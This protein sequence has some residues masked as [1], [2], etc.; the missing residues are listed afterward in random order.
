MSSKLQYIQQIHAV[1]TY[2]TNCDR[3]QMNSLRDGQTLNGKIFSRILT[4]LLHCD[5][6]KLFSTFY[7]YKNFQLQLTVEESQQTV[8]FNFCF[9]ANFKHY[10]LVIH[11]E[12]HAINCSCLFEYCD[13]EIGS[14]FYS[15]DR[16]C[17]IY[18]TSFEIGY[19]FKKCLFQLVGKH[20]FCDIEFVAISLRSL[21]ATCPYQD[22]LVGFRFWNFDRF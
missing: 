6:S 18:I 19:S 7:M 15:L 13:S 22:S 21:A 12:F 8:T 3:L 10:K 5:I 4:R 14:S 11:T 2:F 16:L 1:V 20:V 9:S 17:R